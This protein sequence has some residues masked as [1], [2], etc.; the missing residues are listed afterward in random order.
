LLP[1]HFCFFFVSLR[2]LVLLTVRLAGRSVVS[3]V[4]RLPISWIRVIRGLWR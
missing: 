1:T 2:G 4:P 3:W